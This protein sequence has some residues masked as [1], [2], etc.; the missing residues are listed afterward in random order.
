MLLPGCDGPCT[1]CNTEAPATIKRSKK[2]VTQISHHH[3]REYPSP[4]KLSAS[5]SLPSPATD[6]DK[7]KVPCDRNL[8]ASGSSKGALDACSHMVR[9][10]QADRQSRLATDRTNPDIDINKTR[11]QQEELARNTPLWM[12]VPAAALRMQVPAGAPEIGQKT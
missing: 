6:M 2:T 9:I 11:A 5:P 3:S 8:L 7:G 12:Q 4:P 10:E 1:H